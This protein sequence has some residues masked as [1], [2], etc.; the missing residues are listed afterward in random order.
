VRYL[1][2]T[3]VFSAVMAGNVMVEA[4]LLGLRASEILVPQPVLAEISAGIERLPRSRRERILRQA[5]ARVS[6]SLLRSAWTDEVSQVYGKLKARLM[7]KGTP[8]EDFDIAI[9]AHALV[10]RAVVA[11]DN[12]RHFQ[13]VPGLEVENW[14]RSH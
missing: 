10:E 6:G 11:T 2:D 4:Q 1:L 13:R 9:A 5:F 8:L 14:L 7:A 12:V 3:N